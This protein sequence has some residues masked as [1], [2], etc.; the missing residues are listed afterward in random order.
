MKCL[1]RKLLIDSSKRDS[2]CRWFAFLLM[3]LPIIVEAQSNI[4][5]SR[6]KKQ[7]ME[8]DTYFKSQQLTSLTTKIEKEEKPWGFGFHFSSGTDISKT[9][10]DRIYNQSLSVSGAYKINEKFGL[11]LQSGVSYFAEDNN[12]PKEDGN[13]KWDDLSLSLSQSF[14]EYHKIKF[15]QSVSTFAPISYDSQYEGIKTGL[16]YSLGASHDLYFLSVGHS[17]SASYTLFST[18]FSPTTGRLNSPWS[19]SY[20]LSI[21]LPYKLNK[22]FSVGISE[23][24]STRSAFDND[25]FLTTSTLIYGSMKL[26]K[27]RMSL[28]YL[29]GSYDENLSIRYFYVNEWQQKISAGLSYEI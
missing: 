16:S 5:R 8:N 13:P 20:T 2:V 19:N 25:Y 4:V 12:I 27:F 10:T 3:L 21:G 23:S 26:G 11:G 17:L 29:I 1:V 9:H 14:G 28:N 15:S 7:Y 22:Q 18:E 24:G 6:P